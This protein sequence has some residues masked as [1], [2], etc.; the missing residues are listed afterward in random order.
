MFA[1]AAAAESRK[2]HATYFENLMI[3][4]TY[5]GDMNSWCINKVYYCKEKSMGWLNMRL[6]LHGG[7]GKS[8]CFTEYRGVHI[9]GI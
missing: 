9:Q 1:I 2:D 8:V 3:P 6:A 5:V 4:Y 7:T